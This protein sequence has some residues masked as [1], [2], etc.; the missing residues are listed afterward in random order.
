MFNKK[1]LL[2][3]P[4]FLVLFSMVVFAQSQEGYF[5][6]IKDLSFGMKDDSIKSLRNVLNADIDTKI[7]PNTSS[8]KSYFDDAVRD[9]VV[10]FQKKYAISPSTG[11]VGY[12][13][14][15]ALNGFLKKNFLNISSKQVDFQVGFEGAGQGLIPRS[16]SSSSNSIFDVS[17]ISTTTSRDFVV[18]WMATSTVSNCKGFSSPVVLNWNGDNKPKIGV[19]K[20]SVGSRSATT[21]LYLACSGISNSASSTLVIDRTKA[22]EANMNQATSTATLNFY[23]G[24][25][26]TNYNGPTTT[27]K[28]IW[29][30][31]IKNSCIGTSNPIVNRWN[32]NSKFTSGIETVVLPIGTTTIYLRCTN[33]T[34]VTNTKSIVFSIATSSGQSLIVDDSGPERIKIKTP[35]NGDNIEVG[36]TWY[37]IEYTVKS[38]FATSTRINVRLVGVSRNASNNVW[39]GQ[40][41][42]DSEYK[43]TNCG[44]AQ[45]DVERT[46][47]CDENGLS[48]RVPNKTLLGTY[49]I[50]FID[51]NNSNNVWFSG[52]FNLK[53]DKNISTSTNNTNISSTIIENSL[54]IISPKAGDSITKKSSVEFKFES[55]SGF[56]PARKIELWLIGESNSYKYRLGSFT[57]GDI[58]QNCLEDYRNATLSCRGQSIDI[59]LSGTV[60]AGTY[61]L[62]VTSPS[63]NRSW[64]VSPIYVVPAK[65]NTNATSTATVSESSGG[66]WKLIKSIF[67]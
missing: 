15:T 62:K 35:K 52:S 51:V 8:D 18:L 11:Y 25:N 34:G 38:G 39:I 13:T 3:I 60:K 22:Y 19:E 57:F 29:S 43:A 1:F 20:V 17:D 54:K 41:M 42:L 23:I 9:S 32:N 45:S 30:S 12:V 49:K 26:L 47:L 28:L 56:S 37:P 58:S 61:K 59:R 10:K 21:T 14:K 48:F 2:I 66:F 16:Q 27:H 44:L 5:L 4:V 31:D 24:D 64:F 33:S 6:F 63:D 67:K 36:S 65:T 50:K 46:L 7:S 40:F 53:K 55:L